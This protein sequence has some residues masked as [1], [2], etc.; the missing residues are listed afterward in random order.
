MTDLYKVYYIKPD[1]TE[2]FVNVVG[3]TSR[4]EAEAHVSITKGVKVIGAYLDNNTQTKVCNKLEDIIC[5]GYTYL[6][7]NC[8]F[9][10]YQEAYRDSTYQDNLTGWEKVKKDYRFLSQDLSDQV[11]EQMQQFIMDNM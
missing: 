8:D 7:F 1:N 6:E 5:S 10:K 4:L 3:C 11:I 9:D 2:G